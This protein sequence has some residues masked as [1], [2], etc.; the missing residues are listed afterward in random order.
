[1]RV[2]QNFQKNTGY[3]MIQK[4]NVLNFLKNNNVIAKYSDLSKLQINKSTI[5]R[6]IN[7]GL[8]ERVHSG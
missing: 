1:M 3:T 2:F 6:L 4:E 8:L 7:E 5:F